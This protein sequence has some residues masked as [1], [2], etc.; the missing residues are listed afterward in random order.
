MRLLYLIILTAVVISCTQTMGIKTSGAEKVVKD[1][2]IRTTEIDIDKENQIDVQPKID[3]ISPRDNEIIKGRTL[4]IKLNV[5]N[6]KLVT[7]DRY[8]KE[9]QGYIQVWVDDMEAR[10]S[11]TEFVFENETNGTHAIKAK[12]ML[13][14][15]TLLPYSKTIKVFIP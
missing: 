9:G 7:P 2:Y 3:I 11:N 13:S 8:P 15:N 5:S 4:I 14:N 1:A 10:S 12:L 6:F